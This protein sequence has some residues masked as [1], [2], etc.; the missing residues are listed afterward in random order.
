MKRLNKNNLDN[1]I[2]WTKM[3]YPTS[4][5]H[6]LF[7]EQAAI[8]PNLIALEFEDEKLTYGELL[9]KTN[10]MANYFL[11]QGLSPGQ[12]VAVSMERS[13][14]LIIALFAILQCGASYLPL[15]PKFPIG[16]LEF[17]L[18]DSEASFLLTTKSL[19]SSLPIYSKTIL[20]ENALS[21][22][23]NYPISPVLLTVAQEA[24]AYMMYTSGSTGKPKGVTVTHKN[25]VNFLFSMAIEPG[26]NP[27]DKLLSITTISFDIA[28]LELFLPLIKGAIV[29]FA[30]YQTT[31]DGQL[32]LQL[33]QKK[34]IT[35]LQA[36]PTTWQLLLDSGWETPLR[37]KALCGGEAMPLNLA[38]QLTARCDSL[39]NMYG[40]TETTIWSAIKQINAKDELITI[41]GPIA[42]T[43]IYLLDEHGQAVAPGTIGEIVIGGDGVAQGYWKRPELTA[44]KFIPDSF[45]TEPNAILYRTG[46]LGKLLPNGEFQCLGRID[47]QVKIRG[48]RIE[49]GEIET[50]LNSFPGIKQSAVIVSNYY[51]NE[52]KLIAYFKSNEQ[53][54]DEKIIHEALSKILPEILLPYKY[55]W[56]EDFPITPNGKIDKKSL[57]IPEYTRPDSAPLFKKPNTQLEKDIAK[58]WSEELK[59]PSIGIDDDFFD[60]GGSSVLAQKITSVLRQR[61]SIE[62]PVSKMYIYPTIRELCTILG[63]DKNGEKNKEDLFAFKETKNKT[64]SADIAVIGMAGRFPGSDSMEELWENLKNGKET[65]SYFTKDELDISLPESL[66][67]DPLYIG[68]RGILSS[69]KTFDANFFGLNPQLAAAMDP[70]IRVFLEISFEALEQSG[71]LPK[72][73]KGSI[74]VYSGSEI[75]TYYENNIFSNKE[76][77]SSIGE[78]QIYTVNG[79]DFIAPRTS[80]HLNLKGPS[81]SVH[82][83]CS[84]SLLA[85]AEAVKAIRT[86]MCDVA[87]AGGSS[88]TSPI[89]SGHLYDDGFIKSPDGSTRSFEASGKGTVFS[90]GAG[91]VLLKRLEEAEKD[92]D[93]IYGVIKGV[94][95]NNDGGDKGS[96]MAPS[97]K[98]QAGAIINA[99][100]DAQISP[101]TITY[102]EA[103]GTATPIGDPIEIEGLKIAYGKQEKNGYCALG[104]IK[105]NMGH[106]TAAAGA[107]GLI[108]T[109]LA[110]RHKQIPPMVNFT[111]P[112][113]NIDFDNSPFYINNK[114]IDWNADGKRRAGVSS[115]GIGSTNAHVI[116]EEY[117]MKPLPPST[118]RPLQ[119]LMWSAKS[120]NSLLSYENELGNFIDKSKDNDLADIAYS[121][122]ATRDDFNHRSFLIANTAS[123]AAEKLISLKTKS[124]KSAL[125]KSAPGE[126]GFLFPGQGAQFLQMGKTLY[127]NEEVYRNA[128]DKC[129][130]LLMEDLNLDIRHIIYPEINSGEAE[131]LLK[132]TRLTQPA[133]F[134]TEY[135]LSQ[136]WMS[137]GIKPTFL[138][139]HSIG[140][141]AAAHLAGIMNLKDALHIVAVRGKLI[142][143]LPGGSMLAVRVPIEQLNEVLP[144]TLSLAAINSNQF[145]VVSGTKEDITDFNKKLDSQDIPNKILLT[146]H[147][148][149]SFMMDPILE[150]FKNEVE[151]IKLNI[152]RLPIIS[153][154][155]GT[156]LSDTEATSAIYWVNHLKNT[157]RFADAMD[158]AFGLED[159]IL[160]E[161]GP[162]QTLITL[163][164]QQAVGK[165]IPAFPS[166]TFPKDEQ[167]NEYSTLLNAL[168]DLWI[169]GIKPDWHAFYDQQQRQKIKLPSYVFDRKPCWIEP[170][171]TVETVVIQ[172][173]A[174]ADIP[175]VLNTPIASVETDSATKTNNSRKDSVQFK[176]SEIIRNASGISY[177]SDAA[178]N[179]FLELGLD[180]L[181]LTQ[182]SGKLKKEFDLP[183]TFRQL[184]EVFSTPSLLADYIDLNLPEEDLNESKKEIEIT[185]NEIIESNILIN[186]PQLSSIENQISLEQ[187]VQQIQLLS[188]K[189]DQLQNYRNTTLNGKSALGSLKTEL[190]DAE[191]F[192]PDKVIET[193]ETLQPEKTFD[194]LKIADQQFLENKIADK[195]Y[196]IMANDPPVKGGK[197]G[198]D[199]NGNPA[200][201]IEDSN[202]KGKFI[203][204]QLLES[205][206]HD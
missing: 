197:L 204:I 17:M 93:I 122:S 95:V 44:E 8:F 28:G 35:I 94:G 62:V 53:L 110:M 153:T 100:N 79:K 49:L 206:N 29:V 82:S 114:L 75:N 130:E 137:W 170:L 164:R 158:T 22:L 7:A 81:V 27:D 40:P 102:M 12:I 106:T 174:V 185:P 71:H 47:H 140:E 31:H 21:V 18:E 76:L 4:A 16:R 159:Y 90:D 191:T 5:L 152:P 51:G 189:I 186:K 116:V 48:H 15:D 183:I 192:K 30:D 39:W 126:M 108:K 167:E 177:E 74:G 155:T 145:C 119:I 19:V 205:C 182:L 139:G 2:S 72:H 132:D 120:Q 166:L 33:L 37:L 43:Q 66:R 133:L 10:Q 156:W 6:N 99:F 50:A 178:S 105:S 42:N 61:L 125:L 70:Q 146:S 128:I 14:K 181:S 195:K 160:L 129:A 113:P 175:A 203:K 117:E 24:V 36:T 60:I 124:I 112:N 78:L 199:E 118:T 150:S 148:F 121:L 176:I 173:T 96:F 187:I 131:E 168:G 56:V 135:A 25:L 98:G 196:I 11:S 84:T 3:T 73:Y 138:C 202:K 80:Y 162:G 88:V 23:D 52:D 83:A 65:I 91:V 38:H 103:H 141:F 63:E 1:K 104:S 171:S 87:L 57:P 20:V 41:G 54:K 194:V 97:P 127:D 161:V 55:I 64:V 111:K 136:L 190:L 26:I 101:S 188:Q 143:G 193:N 201:F 67:K 92:G 58:I 200:W 147:A 180:S 85:V 59:I 123:D 69:A 163:A 77:K 109:L 169:R 89:N 68:A 115:F 34:E 144:E 151:K 107:A 142:S 172:K 157:V 32:L 149:H 134:V 165:V 198:R 179:T 46:D 154:V 86:G 45:S 13:P 184:N 9:K